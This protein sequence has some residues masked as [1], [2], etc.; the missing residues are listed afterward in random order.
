MAQ[1][2]MPECGSLEEIASFPRLLP[3]PQSCTAGSLA[4]H[5]DLLAHVHKFHPHCLPSGVPWPSSGL[6]CTQW[7]M[8]PCWED[9]SGKGVYA[10]P[11]GRIMAICARNWRVQGVQIVTSKCG[12]QAPARQI[13]LTARRREKK[14]CGQGDPELGPGKGLLAQN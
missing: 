5:M 7:S 4:W 6:E 13:S 2:P 12:R 9:G 11:G 14:G 1:S 3:T 8:F 10:G